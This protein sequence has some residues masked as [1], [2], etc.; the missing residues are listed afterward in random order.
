MAGL[1]ARREREPG[2]EVDH[3]RRAVALPGKGVVLF[4]GIEQP[5]ARCASRESEQTPVVAGATALLQQKAFTVFSR[6]YEETRRAVLYVRQGSQ[7]VRT[8][9]KDEA[10]YERNF[11]PDSDDPDAL[12][13][14]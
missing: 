6:C 10:W 1:D 3:L 12:E 9:W 11:G 13:C 14:R 8:G 7:G 2:A 5:S 4:D